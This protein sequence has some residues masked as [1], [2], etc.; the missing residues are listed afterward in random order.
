MRHAFLFGGALFAIGLAGSAVFA[1][2][3]HWGPVADALG[4]AGSEMKGGIYRVGLPRTD[5]HVTLDGVE[6]KPALALGSWL[7]FAPMGD[8]A[9]VMG[10][11]VL[12]EDEISPVMK[13]LA[14][15][16]I[17]VTALHNHLLRARPAPFY[18]HVLGRGEPVALAR[19]LHDALVLSKTPLGLLPAAGTGVHQ[20]LLRHSA[21]VKRTA[22]EGEP[23]GRN[24]GEGHDGAGGLG[25]AP[26]RSWR[27]QVRRRATSATLLGEAKAAS[28]KPAAAGRTTGAAGTGAQRHGGA[29]VAMAGSGL[30]GRGGGAQGAHR[31]RP[32]RRDCAAEG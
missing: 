27:R 24:D 18:M 17:E 14:E 5:L 32:R 9:M 30:V 28:S 8:V 29:V 22:T 6:L 23:N 4:K 3:I 2:E 26:P 1:D 13:K 11:L 15:G 31:R 10:D 19:T 7:A 25:G 16:G 20:G 21:A 12:T